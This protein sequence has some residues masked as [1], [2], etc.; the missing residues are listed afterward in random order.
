MWPANHVMHLC[1]IKT[2]LKGIKVYSIGKTRETTPGCYSM[3][4]ISLSYIDFIIIIIII[5]I[6]TTIY[7]LSIK[8]PKGFVDKN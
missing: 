6:T 5:I 2:H 1:S 3:G 7:T 4:H 8:D